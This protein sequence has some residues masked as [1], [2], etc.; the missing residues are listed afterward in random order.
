MQ[1]IKDLVAQ[2]QARANAFNMESARR[3]CHRLAASAYLML[4]AT[5]PARAVAT[6][7]SASLAWSVVGACCC[8]GGDDDEPA[9]AVVP[10][11]H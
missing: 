10:A 8:A 11:R 3:V 7:V 5:V 1:D 9:I 4:C 6:L 2:A